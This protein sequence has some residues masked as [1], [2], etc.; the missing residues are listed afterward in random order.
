M[1]Q[2]QLTEAQVEEY[3]LEQ[4]MDSYYERRQRE[5]GKAY[6]EFCHSWGDK[7]EVGKV[8]VDGGE[9]MDICNGCREE[10]E[11]TLNEYEGEVEE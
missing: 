3:V 9:E 2:L 6:C 10:L 4:G 8:K 11:M 5:Q 1:T 7:S